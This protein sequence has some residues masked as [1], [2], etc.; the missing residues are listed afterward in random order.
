MKDN[1]YLMIVRFNGLQEHILK[2]I[3]DTI[4]EH[5]SIYIKSIYVYKILIFIYYIVT[6][7]QWKD[8]NE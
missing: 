3:F 1:V 6:I 8:G 5:E 4:S 7:N 2:F